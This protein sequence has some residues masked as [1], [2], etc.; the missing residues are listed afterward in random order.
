MLFR[1]LTDHGRHATVYGRAVKWTMEKRRQKRRRDSISTL[2][3]VDDDILSDVVGI[4]RADLKRTL[5]APLGVDAAAQIR[6]LQDRRNI[7]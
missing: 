5:A 1:S 6:R 2:L 7:Q 3:N 4:S